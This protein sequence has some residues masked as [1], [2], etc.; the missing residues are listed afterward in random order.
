VFKFNPFMYY[1]RIFS[2]SDVDFDL[3]ISKIKLKLLGA[4]DIGSVASKME[5][6][7]LMIP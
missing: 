2:M 5:I 4:N 7:Y 6:M 3:N 1:F